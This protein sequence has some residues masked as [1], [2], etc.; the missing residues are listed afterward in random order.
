MIRRIGN[1]H[2]FFRSILLLIT[3]VIYTTSNAQRGFPSPTMQFNSINHTQRFQREAFYRNSFSNN[4]FL[5]RVCGPIKFKPLTPNIDVKEGAVAALANASSFNLSYS[6]NMSVNKQATEEEYLAKKTSRYRKDTARVNQFRHSWLQNRKAVFEPRFE[7]AFNE[8]GKGNGINGVN[9][10]N[11]NPVTIE[12]ITTRMDLGLDQLI[13]KPSY[14]NVE[15][16]F[17]D[18]AGTTL[19]RYSIEH[20]GSLSDHEVDEGTRMAECYDRAAEILLQHHMAE[21]QKQN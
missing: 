19:L 15:C 8:Y 1:K 9:Y 11:D 14:I 16:V 10:N 21:L 13:K 3:S 6:Y 17:K 5:Y 18:A 4:R 12:I 7:S 2:C 20:A